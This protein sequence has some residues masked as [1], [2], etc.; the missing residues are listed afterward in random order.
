M[1]IPIVQDGLITGTS[2]IHR[3]Y[4]CNPDYGVGII[5]YVVYHGQNFKLIAQDANT[6]SI[7]SIC[8]LLVNNV[9]RCMFQEQTRKKW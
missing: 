6:I 3:N 5:V 7:N 2:F 9:A 1:L 8:P 4:S